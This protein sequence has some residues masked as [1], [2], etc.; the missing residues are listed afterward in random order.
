MQARLGKL[1]ETVGASKSNWNISRAKSEFV[2]GVDQGLK[3][4]N[5]F[6]ATFVNAIRNAFSFTNKAKIEETKTNLQSV[7][8]NIQNKTDDRV[9]IPSKTKVQALDQYTKMDVSIKNLIMTKSF[10]CFNSFADI[11]PNTKCRNL[12]SPKDLCAHIGVC[13]M[14]FFGD[15]WKLAKVL[16][17]V[18]SFDKIPT[19]D[20]SILSESPS[21]S[22]DV[23]NHHWVK[24]LLFPSIESLNIIES[25]HIPSINPIEE[26]M[27]LGMIDVA[28][29]NICVWVNEDTIKDIAFVEHIS[30]IKK[31]LSSELN[32][33]D[34]ARVV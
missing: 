3:V 15:D 9:K 22:N 1:S 14:I 6:F 5:V 29:S 26:T 12:F 33:M 2:Q 23:R 24:L 27:A 21:L 4:E 18:N 11:V 32:G 7:T 17:I 28:M 30:I 34:L 13:E 8:T 19:S 31:G 20:S 25:V 10:F 16:D